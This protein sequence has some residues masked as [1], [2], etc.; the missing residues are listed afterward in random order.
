M[1]PGQVGAAGGRPDQSAMNPD[2]F[3]AT[4]I[5]Y[6]LITRSWERRFPTRELVE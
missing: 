1:I 2:F 4:A 3:S 5:D 6:V